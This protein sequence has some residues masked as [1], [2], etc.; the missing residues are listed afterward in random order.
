LPLFEQGALNPQK[1]GSWLSLVGEVISLHDDPSGRRLVLLD[2]HLLMTKPLWFSS[3]A[4]LVGIQPGD[5]LRVAGYLQ[6]SRQ[7]APEFSSAPWLLAESIQ[8]LR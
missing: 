7:W 5:Q 1:V 8:G 4:Q 6:P 3:D 2:T